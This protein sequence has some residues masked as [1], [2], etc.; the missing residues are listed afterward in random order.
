[1]SKNIKKQKQKQKQNPIIPIGLLIVFVL[2][3]YRSRRSSGESTITKTPIEKYALVAEAVRGKNSNYYLVMDITRITNNKIYCTG[4]IQAGIDKVGETSESFQFEPQMFNLTSEVTDT[5]DVE[6]EI[7]IQN[8]FGNMYEWEPQPGNPAEGLWFRTDSGEFTSNHLFRQYESNSFG[9]GSGRSG[10]KTTDGYKAFIS[11]ND[12]NVIFN[13]KKDVTSD[14]DY[15]LGSIEF[16]IEKMNLTK[17][18]EGEV[19]V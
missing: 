19:I 13:F 17:Y 5:I 4:Y 2:V 12:N 10:Y 11:I 15:T 6:K 3:L 14:D 7:S 16:P 8:I 1:M 9:G 18:P